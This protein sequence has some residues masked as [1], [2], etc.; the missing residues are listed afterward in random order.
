MLWRYRDLQIDPS[1]SDMFK[2]WDVHIHY[3]SGS[4]RMLHSPWKLGEYG[5]LTLR[6]SFSYTEFSNIVFNTDFRNSLRVFSQKGPTAAPSDWVN[7]EYLNREWWFFPRDKGVIH[8][9]SWES[10]LCGIFTLALASPCARW[11]ATGP[12]TKEG[13]PELRKPVL[14]CLSGQCTDLLR[15]LDL[16]KWSDFPALPGA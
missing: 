15:L 10:V 2:L 1:H 4:I 8:Q 3:I 9:I 12:S 11:H 6:L 5:H 16:Y 13:S 7:F 14:F